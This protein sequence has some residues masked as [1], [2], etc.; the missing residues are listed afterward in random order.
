[1][2]SSDLV[3][4]RNLPFSLNHSDIEPLMVNV[5]VSMSEDVLWKPKWPK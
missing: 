4:L 1:M 3:L 2:N 5:A